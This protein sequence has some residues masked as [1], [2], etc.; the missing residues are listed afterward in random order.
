M[1]ESMLAGFPSM[2]GMI[3]ISAHNSFGNGFAA[4]GL[5]LTIVFD[6]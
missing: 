6:A 3:I 5:L 1:D 2:G 4:P